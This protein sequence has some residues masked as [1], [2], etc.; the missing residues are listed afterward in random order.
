MTE[1]DLPV[2]LLHNLDFSWGAS[3]LKNAVRE[4]DFLENEIIRQGYVVKNSPLFD[5]N[6]RGLLSDIN[7][8]EHIIFNWCEN[9][10]GI[11]KSEAT[12]IKILDEMG[13]TYTGSPSDVVEK[14]WDKPAI[15]K[16]LEENRIPT[17]TWRVFESPDCEDWHCFPAIVKPAREHCSYGVTSESVVTNTEEISSRIKYILDKFKGPALVEDFIDGREFHVSVWGNGDI[18]ILPPAEMDF[19]RCN[20]FHERL[21]TYESKFEPDSVLFN[22]IGVVVP[23][24][25]TE[26]ELDCLRA[27]CITAYKLLGCRDYARMDIRLRD[28]IFYFLDINPNPDIG[29][30]TSMAFA[31]QSLGLS[32]GQMIAHL[33]H[34]ACLR[35][36]CFS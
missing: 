14:S 22:K 26:N 29:Y 31:A 12:V 24:K 18:E 9:I 3:D 36:P 10:P 20:D 17:P 27:S 2:V 23:A 33:I 1:K 6:L 16:M 25:L 35:H 8:N 4:V 19:S 15:K 32:Y 13:F 11:P 34:F 5:S 28:G 7:P 21:C 30:E